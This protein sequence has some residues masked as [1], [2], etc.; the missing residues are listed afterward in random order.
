M[1]HYQ[2]LT[3]HGHSVIRRSVRE[4]F[5]GGWRCHRHTPAAAGAVIRNV[6]GLWHNAGQ[7]DRYVF[8]A[9]R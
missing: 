7:Y 3:A 6:Q 8:A 1:E 2:G 9:L 5:Q 4:V